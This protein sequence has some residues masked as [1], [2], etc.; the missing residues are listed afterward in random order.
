MSMSPPDATPLLVEITPDAFPAY[1]LE[2]DG[3]LFHSHEP[4]PYPLPADTPEQQR[5]NVTHVA[6]N[7]LIGANYVGP[8]PD[9]LAREPHRPRI[10]LDLCTGTGRWVIDM[11]REFPHVSFRGFDI[12]PIATRYPPFNAQ[13]EVHDVNSRYRWEDGSIDLVYARSISMA[14]HDYPTVLQEVAR[15]LRPGGLFISYEWGRYPAFHPSV[16]VKPPIHGVERF[17]NVLEEAL[18]TVRDIYPIAPHIPSYLID[19]GHFDDISPEHFNMP[20]GPW[21]NDEELRKLGRAFRASLRRYANSVKPL[22]YE[23]GWTEEDV[24]EITQNYIHDLETVRGMVCRLY[25]VHARRI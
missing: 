15:V 8:V 9:V 20:V 5:L 13:F 25:T 10:A 6:L 16:T 3:R 14:V 22:L 21:Q 24:R 1:F 18:E 12:V 7:R 17:F 11:A 19:S 4:S 23:A 2:R